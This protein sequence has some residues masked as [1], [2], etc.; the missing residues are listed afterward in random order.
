LGIRH[1]RHQGPMLCSLAK[2]ALSG[3]KRGRAVAQLPAPEHRSIVPARPPA[4]LDAYRKWSGAPAD[5]DHVPAHF[6]PQW[7]MPLLA[8]VL[9]E[10]P[11]PMTKILNQGC[12]LRRRT[13]LPAGEPLHT[14]ARL[15]SVIESAGKVRIET[16][17]TCGTE[18][19]PEAIE[20]VVHSIV[21]LPRRGAG[22]RPMRRIGNAAP[23]PMLAIAD[24][25][26][27]RGS[28]FRYA[29][30]SGDFNPI[31]WIAPIARLAGFKGTI[32]HGFASMALIDEHLNR[33]FGSPTAELDLRFIA[34][35]V[36]PTRLHLI[37]AD[38]SDNDGSLLVELRLPDGR[39][40][41]AGRV[42]PARA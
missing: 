12:T 5:S 16:R 22:K 1:I 28:G 36:M 11:Y 31:H 29:C 42:T 14:S 41:A 18:A 21:P 37:A 34:P 3:K 20:A 35:V 30:L 8:D 33:H 7:A 24:I 38:R 15:E 10:L 32:L 39:V 13:P 6:F 19:Q 4:L 2:I 17:L 26:V 40:A 9:G 23:G 25:D 27:P